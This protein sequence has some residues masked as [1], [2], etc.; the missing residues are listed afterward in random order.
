[1]TRRD[2]VAVLWALASVGLGVVAGLAGCFALVVLASP[3]CTSGC[4]DGV[5]AW[6]ALPV[7]ATSAPA[8]V[9]ALLAAFRYAS[10][11]RTR[12]ARRT[13]M[14]AG[15]VMALMVGWVT[16]PAWVDTWV[17]SPIFFVPFVAGVVLLICARWMRVE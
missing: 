2:W 1:M 14:A 8:C 15:G 10:G 3:S 9:L 6:F 4:E 11:G 16:W 13:L 5:P 12:S 17:V 7:L